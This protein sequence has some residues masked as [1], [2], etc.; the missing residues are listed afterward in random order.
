MAVTAGRAFVELVVRGKE[1]VSKELKAV[2]NRLER[3]GNIVK[4]MGAMIGRAAMVG[5]VAGFA[6]LS[7]VMVV[8][9]KKASDMQETLNKFSVAFGDA[10]ES[11][12]AWSD[13]TAK[14]F[15]RSSAEV[16][17]FLADFKAF[18]NPLGM[19]S[20]ASDSMAQSLTRLSYDMASLHN[21][22]DAD[23]M[24]DL[25]AAMAGSGEVLQ[26]YGIQLNETTVK[27]ELLNQGLNPANATAAQK[28]MARYNIILQQ[29]SDAQGDVARS[30]GSFA[31][32]QKALKARVDDILV[33]VGQKLLP[34]LE[35]LMTDLQA[36]MA[37]LFGTSDA[38]GTATQAMDGLTQMIDGM[39]GPVMIAMRAWFGLKGIFD[40]LVA[41]GAKL[42]ATLA[43]IATLVADNPAAEF[44]A[45][46]QASQLK[47]FAAQAGAL[48][49]TMDKMANDTFANAGDSFNKAFGDD[50][51][52]AMDAE[53]NKIKQQL[54][55]A[56]TEY[57]QLTS[58]GDEVKKAVE[59]AAAKIKEA[60]DRMVEAASPESLESS[61]VVAYQRFQ[62]NR[63]NEQNRWLGKIFNQ[64]AKANIVLGE[65]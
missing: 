2:E 36:A 26:K 5:G 57:K 8:A 17:T 27:Q 35:K 49:V 10:T 39:G 18:L 44:L 45:G 23:A 24:N 15:G 25:R 65:A 54:Q 3:F 11:M 59:P 64:L 1:N 16:K 60:S 48:S 33:A 47:M 20:E 30:S 34:I 14:S 7:G 12:L 42:V 28:A 21:V 53:R 46:D 37:I 32:Q 19:A 55:Q 41:A 56:E 43:K 38:T 31:N 6:A 22:T 29:S 52:K 62:E 58:F 13:Q 63:M 40:L 4:R 51:L 61:S 9:T 50:L